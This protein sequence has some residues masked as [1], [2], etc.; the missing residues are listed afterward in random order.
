MAKPT[1][2]FEYIELKYDN[3]T[4]QINTWLKSVYN[5][6]ALNLNS[7]SPYG[8]ILNVQKELFQH[9]IIYLKNAVR[10][11]DIETTQDIKVIR[12]VALVS[13]LQPSRS[14]SA[15][16]T[17]KFILKVGVDLSKDIKD[18]TVIFEDG[19]VLKSKTNSLKYIVN[20]NVQKNVYSLSSIKNSFYVPIIQGIYDTQNFTGDGSANQSYS[21]N[22]PGNKQ[23]DNFNYS[24]KCNGT[25]ISTKDSLYDML[26]NEYSC[27][28]RSGFNGGIDVF[29]GTGNNGFIPSRG[30]LIEVKYLL[31]DGSSGELLSPSPND[32]K[33]EGD[34]YDGQGNVINVE[35]LFD[36][37]VDGDI[38]FASDGETIEFTKAT[39]PY[40][41]RN[42]V[43]GT[44]NQF[45]F[46][47]LKLNMFSKVNAYNKLD[48]NNFS[49]TDKV[50][51][52]SIKKINTNIN[53]NSS[54][55]LILSSLNNFNDLYS[56]YKTNT[57]D[58]EIYLYLI[59]SI[60]KYFNDTVNYFNIPFDA[61]YLDDS[62][63]YKIN[64]YLRQLGTLSPT[65]E[66]NIIQPKISRYVMHVYIRRFDYANEDNI[67]QQINALTSDYLLNNSRFDRIPKS[68]FITLFKGID[69]VDSASVYFVC[70]K[71]ESYHKQAA[72]LGYT[73]PI[74]DNN[75]D[76]LVLDTTTRIN[77]KPQT[78]LSNPI[79]IV[80]GKIVPNTAYDPKLMLGIDSVHGDIICEKDEYAI[81][82]G[83]WRDRK[84][85]WYNE[86]MSDNSLGAINIVFNGITEK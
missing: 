74:D 64:Q 75:F 29:F 9:N 15:T 55:D 73:K 69:G 33:I 67:R 27:Y 40:V 43:L 19:L 14:I 22:I 32:W 18:A 72:D 21:V 2:F 7:S 42:F 84:G 25:Y 4:D 5:K 61:F 58:N 50:I 46:H 30:S 12:Q 53:N 65:I 10:V 56:K 68:D 1:R 37:Y 24:V 59:P 16:G 57:N 71:N 80:S 31:S 60:K 20:L 85:I 41:S 36:I 62:E 39:I 66:I 3:L 8:Q 13:G 47:L 54:K 23:V 81:I 79:K 6:S 86:E 11:L 76:A 35:N 28:V 83:G 52:D 17:L 70:E 77:I 34:V 63:K 49:I 51:E 26:Q 82:R 45:I 78:I 48:D 44:P 38:N